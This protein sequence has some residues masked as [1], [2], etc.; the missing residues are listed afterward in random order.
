MVRSAE[1]PNLLKIQTFL[2]K[3]SRLLLMSA[4]RIHARGSGGV[5]S[6]KTVK[7]VRAPF[8]G[9]RGGIN[10]TIV[11]TTSASATVTA[12]VREAFYCVTDQSVHFDLHVHTVNE[13][14]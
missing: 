14:A 10:R 5:S 1:T 3:T 2:S 12:I 13:T 9:H 6:T 7:L 4:L 8:Y 11:L